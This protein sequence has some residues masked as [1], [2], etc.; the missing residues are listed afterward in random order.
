MSA[1]KTS[2][3]EAAISLSRTETVEI[4]QVGATTGI[5]LA[6]DPARSNKQFHVFRGCS[7]AA[8]ALAEVECRTARVD[9]GSKGT[10]ITLALNE[11]LAPTGAEVLARLGKPK[12]IQVPLQK[13]GAEGSAIYVYEIPGGELRF[14]LRAGSPDAV[15]SIAIDRTSPAPRVRI[16]SR[17]AKWGKADLTPFT[18]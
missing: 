4:E 6:L 13:A 15:L 2:I 16:K 1:N 7:D 18:A 8:G 5:K 10:L 12:S 3:L 11:A 9:A 14:E 17:L